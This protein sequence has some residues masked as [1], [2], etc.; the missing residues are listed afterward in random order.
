L[1]ATG[2]EVPALQ[3]RPDLDPLL[4]EEWEAFGMLS[5]A[6]PV[7][8]GLSGIP[9]SEMAIYCALFDV[10]PEERSRFVRIMQAMDR[11]YLEY[12]GSEEA[13]KKPKAK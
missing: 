10:P 6:R 12:H 7:G 13:K 3:N 9:L 1:A 5:R 8:M 11:T 4:A 2:V